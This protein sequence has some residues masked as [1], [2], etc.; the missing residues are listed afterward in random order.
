VIWSTGTTIFSH[1]EYQTLDMAGGDLSKL[2]GQALLL[3]QHSRYADDVIGVVEEG[4]VD[5]PIGVSIVRF[6]HHDRV[7]HFF[8][9]LLDKIPLGISLGYRITEAE[10]APDHRPDRPHYIARRWVADEISI[11]ACG[12]DEGAGF[13]PATLAELVELRE[14]KRIARTIV[15]R[16]ARATALKAAEWR[17]WATNGGATT[18]AAAVGV[19]E[20]KIVSPLAEAVERHL[21]ELL[22]Q[23]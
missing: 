13:V 7:E 12:A 11:V 2:N 4:W 1:G 20:H 16:I 18:I 21:A 23:T 8:S 6:A 22:D 3:V 10:E 19:P 9:M 5:G 15:E 14:Q 17:H